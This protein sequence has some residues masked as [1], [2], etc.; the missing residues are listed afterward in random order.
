MASTGSIVRWIP[1]FMSDTGD[2][3]AGSPVRGPGQWKDMALGAAWLIGRGGSLACQGPVAVHLDAGD[4]FTSYYYALHGRE[5]IKARV[6]FI[7]LALSSYGTDPGKSSATGHFTLPNGTSHVWSLEP[8]IDPVTGTPTDKQTGQTKNFRVIEIITSPTNTVENI[9]AAPMSIV[10]YAAST[11]EVIVSGVLCRDI[12]MSEVYRYAGA[13]EEAPD[14]VAG[15]NSGDSIR[16]IASETVGV[17]AVAD[18]QISSTAGSGIRN[19]ARRGSLFSWC[20][21]RAPVVVT[22]TPGYTTIFRQAPPILGR[23]LHYSSGTTPETT[24][25]VKVSVLATTNSGTL[26]ATVRVTESTSGNTAS[27]TVNSFVGTWYS[28]DLA[29]DCDDMTRIDVYGGTRSGGRCTLTFD[30]RVETAA[31]VTI[32]AV[33]VGEHRQ[34]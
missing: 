13:T 5:Q 19:E 1:P 24:R 15:F 33:T 20:D 21:A 26:T 32:Y 16:H 31:S 23:Y 12:P 9:L 17:N 11:A 18:T 30:A 25:I 10:R 4:Y 6:W 2:I 7:G 29:I 28:M 14:G 3:R 22:S 8:I 27:I 34:L